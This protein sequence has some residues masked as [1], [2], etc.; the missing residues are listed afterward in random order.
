[1]KKIITI[2]L[3][4]LI[5]FVAS[6]FISYTNQPT[7]IK[8]II[9]KSWPKPVY[10]FNSNP[11]T[12]EG[13]ELGKKL[14]YDERLSV[15][16]ST[17]CASCHQQFAAFATY[18]HD[19]SHGVNNGLTTRNATAL[20][21]LAWQKEFMA[22]GSIHHL[23]AQ[24]LFPLTAPNEMGENLEHLIKKL[25]TDATYRKMFKAAFGSST[26]TTQNLT[27]AFS[28]FLVTLV[29][30]NSKYDK[31]LRGEA[32]FNLPEKL[33]YEIFQKKCVACHTEPM[34]TDYS[35]RNIGL[36]INENTKDEG[37]KNI[38]H[39]SSDS[40]KFR[41]PSLRNIV[42]TFPYGHD[43]RFFTLMNVFEHYRKNN[44]PLSNYEIGQLTSF[45]YTLT[46]SSFI[47]NK[48]FAPQ[49]YNITPYFKD[50]H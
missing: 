9:P 42:L 39:L 28:Q 3:I 5:V 41:V 17:S 50:K 14:F 47:T 30:S 29:S 7:P 20:Q 45:L 46:D 25:Q 16:S 23:D 49:G 36:S 33:G 10:D 15:D 19:L 12:V 32:N 18:D 2:L 8:F 27:K 34:F 43:G 4:C 38:T 44:L 48:K 11:L 26:I 24:P 35:Y 1:L 13:F 21:N 22:D 6:S 40:L 37:R 31:V